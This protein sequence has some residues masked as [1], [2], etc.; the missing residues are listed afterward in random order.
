MTD[1]DPE[2]R[3]Q[4]EWMEVVYRFAQ[5]L[6]DKHLSNPWPNIPVLPEAMKYLM[7]ELW[8]RGF[9]Q[10]EIRDAFDAAILDMP[11]YTAGQEKR[12]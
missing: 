1:Y 7:T 6:K 12:S 11:T 4:D 3:W 10:T 9:S 2:D 5:T 8:D